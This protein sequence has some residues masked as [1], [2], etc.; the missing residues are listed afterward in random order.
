MNFVDTYIKPVG[1]FLFQRYYRNKFF[2]ESRIR[3]RQGQ[4]IK[5]NYN[6][7]AEKIIVFLVPGADRYTGKDI[8]SG[9][10]LSIASLYNETVN[11]KAEHRAEVLMCTFPGEPLLL[12]HTNFANNIVVYS[13]SQVSRY[14]VSLQNLVLHIPEYLAVHFEGRLNKEQKSFLNKIPVF[15]I[16]ILNQNIHLMPSRPVIQSL[17]QLATKV[18]VTTAHKKYCNQEWRRAFNVPLHHFSTFASPE[19]YSYVNYADKENI[20]LF[21]P[22]DAEKNAHVG[23]LLEEKIPGLKTRVINGLTYE[24]YKK[25]IGRAKWCITFGEGL[26]FYF[27]EPVF[28]GSVSFAIYNDKFFTTSFKELK[29]V[30]SSYES[31][32]EKIAETIIELDSKDVYTRYNKMEFDLCADQYSYTRYQQNIS[33][34]YQGHY[35]YP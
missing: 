35:T 32:A 20:L 8:I 30:Y 18:T 1:K 17:E 16:N 26:D 24:E 29:T 22:D 25:L 3:S 11:C 6:R 10:V 4:L 13:F 19:R 28:S 31:L 14:F 15:H 33:A 9:G 34:F 12:Q 23:K 5:T 2:R 27:I 7:A 21:S